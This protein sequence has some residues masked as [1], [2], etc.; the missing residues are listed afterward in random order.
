MSEQLLDI[1]INQEDRLQHEKNQIELAYQ[2]IEREEGKAKALAKER[3]EAFKKMYKPVSNGISYIL[4]QVAKTPCMIGVPQAHLDALVNS[5][6]TVA[7]SVKKTQ[8]SCFICPSCA[9]MYAKESVKKTKQMFGNTKK[10]SLCY[11]EEGILQIT[12]SD[13]AR[14]KAPILSDPEILASNK[15]RRDRLNGLDERKKI[16]LALEKEKEDEKPKF[17]KVSILTNAIEQLY[18]LVELEEVGSFEAEAIIKPLQTIIL[19]VKMKNSSI[20]VCE[21]CKP[22]IDTSRIKDVTG[23]EDKYRCPICTRNE[24]TVRFLLK[25]KN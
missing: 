18:E 16:I 10:C 25:A 11:K 8:S 3:E 17:P 20:A 2:E 15:A 4:K 24:A 5:A 21:D 23:V 9:G 12:F 14:I 6:Y 19:R 22:L 13:M 7:L 1:A